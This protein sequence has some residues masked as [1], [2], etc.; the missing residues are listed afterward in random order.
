[1]GCGSDTDPLLVGV[2]TRKLL[3][4]IDRDPSPLVSHMD[5]TFNLNH[6]VYPV[7]VCSVSDASRHFHLFIASQQTHVQYQQA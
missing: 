5:T 4:V 6:L 1:V 7:F 3:R 2:T